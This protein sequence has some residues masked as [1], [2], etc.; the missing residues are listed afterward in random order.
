MATELLYW[1]R[2]PLTGEIILLIVV[3]LP[4]YCY[5]QARQGWRDLRRNLK[6]AAW[7]ICY[8]PMIA[9]LSWAGSSKFGGHGYLSYG[10]DLAMVAAVGVVFYIWGVRAL[11][12]PSVE[13]RLR[14]R[15]CVRSGALPA[16]ASCRKPAGKSGWE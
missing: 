11:A 8:L 1:A 4:V 15:E 7:M 5:Y 14:R 12:H 2:W 13:S 16:G 6:G 3:A 9:L 10:T